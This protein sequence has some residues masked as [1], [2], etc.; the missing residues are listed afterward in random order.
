VPN[1]PIDAARIMQMIHRNKKYR[2]AGQDKLRV[3]AD[4][5]A[6]DERITRVKQLFSELAAPPEPVKSAKKR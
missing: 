1:P 5:H 6:I 3:E 4:L 2:L